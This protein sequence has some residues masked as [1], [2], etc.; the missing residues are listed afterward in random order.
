MEYKLP[1]RLKSDYDG[2]SC[3]VDFFEITRNLKNEHIIIDFNN[4]SWFEANLCVALGSILYKIKENNTISFIN[5]GEKVLSIL[6]KNRFLYHFDGEYKE[7]VHSTTI[8]FRQFKINDE[9]AFIDYLDRELL[10]QPD[11]PKMTP[12][13]KNSISS[14]IYE[15][16]SNAYTHGGCDF[17]YTCGQYY[18]NRKVLDFTMADLGTTIRSKVRS[19]LKD[20]SLSGSKTISWAVEEGHTTK[21]GPHPGGLGL[22]LIREFLKLNEGKIQIVSSNGY[23]E[24]KKG[25]IFAQDFKNAFVGTIVNLE[26]NIDDKKSY[27]LKTELDPQDIF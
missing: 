18:P 12:L 5:I 23:W 27:A 9:I 21:T 26:F 3:F 15:I 10:S 19:F 16:Y 7:D 13:L 20:K 2:Y 14:K 4:G 25:V 24:E 11:L 22:S 8:K 1:S 6:Q 17:V